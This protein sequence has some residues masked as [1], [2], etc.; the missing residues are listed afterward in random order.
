MSAGQSAGELSLRRNGALPIQVS[1]AAARL[2]LMTHFIAWLESSNIAQLPAIG[3]SPEL[4]DRLRRLTV[5]D[6]MRVATAPCG[7]TLLVDPGAM[8]A[9]L[10]R[11]E[12]QQ[13]ERAQYEHFIR[14]GASPAL[15]GRLF[16]VS[17]IQVRRKRAMI[18]PNL[19]VGG[20]PALPDEGQR[21][22]V[23]SR[24]RDLQQRAEMSERERYW[25]LHEAF[26]DFLLVALEDVIERPAA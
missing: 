19:T 12:G 20:R 6:A 4:V 15:V 21:E 23:R 11:V 26:P 3:L 16:C 9:Q 1:D 10:A 13:H 17:A 22:A 18:A 5:V 2:A 24:W 14:A 8:E 25:A 7:L